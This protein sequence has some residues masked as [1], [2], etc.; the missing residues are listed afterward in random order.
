MAASRRP[1]RRGFNSVARAGR[2]LRGS[3]WAQALGECLAQGPDTTASWMEQRTRLL[4]SDTYSR[5]GLLELR[6]QACLLKLYLAKSPWQRLAFR[7]G[8]S[9]AL[10][11]FDMA[12]ALADRGLPVPAPRACVQVEEGMLL[13]TEGIP[14]GRDLR[15]LW[16]EQPEAGRAELLMR[17]AADTLAA[18]HLAGFAHGDGK[19][20]NLLWCGERLLLVDLDA[21]RQVKAGPGAGLPLPPRQLRDLARFTVDAQELGATPPQYDIFLRRYAERMSCAREDLLSAIED[22]ANAIRLRHARKYGI[23]RV[24]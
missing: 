2:T 24:R 18:L 6:G 8:Y 15:A 17:G 21:V 7:L 1:C 20:S 14:D 12:Q 11:S 23:G 3:L 4:K 19:W 5:V 9:R 10:R 16:L 22:P 13:L